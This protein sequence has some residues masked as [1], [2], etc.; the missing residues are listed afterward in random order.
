MAPILVEVRNVYGRELIYP[1]N[2]NA[3]RVCALLCKK[4]LSR[5]DLAILKELGHEVNERLV[6]KVAA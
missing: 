3:A 4:T 2:L 1:A 5:S 6:G